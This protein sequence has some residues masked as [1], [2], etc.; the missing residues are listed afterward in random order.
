MKE[1]DVLSLIPQRPPFIMVGQLRYADE[2]KAESSFIV[3]TDNVLTN[4]GF[5]SEAGIIENIAQSAALHAGFVARKLGREP[6]R[7]MIGGIKNLSIGRLPKVEEVINTTIS[8]EHEVIN[9]KIVKG[10]VSVGQYVIAECEMK[11]FLF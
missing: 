5:F 10:I 3:S 6:P 2:K 1:N 7:G 4:D 8:L 11:V 9:A